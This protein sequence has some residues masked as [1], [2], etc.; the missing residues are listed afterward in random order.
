M[1]TTAPLAEDNI[2]CLQQTIRLLQQLDDDA[3]CARDPLCFN[4]SV[5]GHL[6]H[7][8][9]HYRSFLAGLGT[10]RVDYDSRQR[11]PR[12]EKERGYAV[13]QIRD[14]LAEL[15]MIVVEDLAGEMWVKMDSDNKRA[16]AAD[17][18]RSSVGREL[19]F[20]VSHTVHH[21]AIV[22]VMLRL[23]GV[24]PD[25]DFGVAPSTLRY[26]ESKKALASCVQLP[27]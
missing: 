1:T 23:R 4:A 7:D 14:V 11:D 5:G 17:W 26:Q 25:K 22:A 15:E 6:R 21:N 12:I 19:Q 13:H 18:Y 8:L 9:D 20:L 24:E 16:E 27:G 3:Y 2:R 10:G